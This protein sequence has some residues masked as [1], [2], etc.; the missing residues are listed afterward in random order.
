MHEAHQELA[1]LGELLLEAHGPVPAFSRQAGVL[2]GE[3]S[4]VQLA[5]PLEPKFPS[6]LTIRN[7]SQGGLDQVLQRARHSLSELTQ[8]LGD[9]FR[10]D[11]I[12]GPYP[13]FHPGGRPNKKAIEGEDLSDCRRESFLLRFQVGGLVAVD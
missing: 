12:A 10:V 3:H 7:A 1:L 4:P 9:G 2:T 13:A 8:V 11:G 5:V 6:E